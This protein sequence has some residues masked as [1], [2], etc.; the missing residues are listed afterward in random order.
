MGNMSFA[1]PIASVQEFY[2]HALAIEHEAEERYT[3]LAV[4]F[5]DRGE[6]VLAGLCRNLAVHEG[7]HY[8]ELLDACAHMKL[9][10]IAPGEYRWLEGGA[11]ESAAREFVYRVARPRDLL[12]IALQAE[13]RARDYFVWIARSALSEEVRELAAVMAAE[14]L[15]H[16]RWVRDALEYHRATA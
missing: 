12:E 1:P 11:P 16:V 10:E 8:R 2:A 6:T 13:L 4:Y 7:E 5:D 15:Q 9:P 14:E 3:E